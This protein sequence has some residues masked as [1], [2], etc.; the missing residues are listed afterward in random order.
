MNAFQNLLCHLESIGAAAERDGRGVKKFC[1][2]LAGNVEHYFAFCSKAI[3]TDFDPVYVAAMYLDPYF[4]QM[5]SGEEVEEAVDYLKNRV[6]QADLRRPTSGNTASSAGTATSAS[7]GT[8]SSASSA[9]AGTSTS[10]SGT[11][12]SASRTSKPRDQED[13]GG[14]SLPKRLHLFT[15]VKMPDKQAETPERDRGF[16]VRFRNDIKRVEELYEP[17]R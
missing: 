4:S 2:T 11:S 12:T 13:D 3:H 8:A 7:A 14:P 16:D 1:Q 9:S 10:A 5:L 6:Y 17:L 15:F